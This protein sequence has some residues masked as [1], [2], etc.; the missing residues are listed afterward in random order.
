MGWI[1]NKIQLNLERYK[2]Q[3]STGNRNQQKKP[4][5]SIVVHS[6]LMNDMWP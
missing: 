4:S 6:A 1:G 5:E 2:L 3:Q